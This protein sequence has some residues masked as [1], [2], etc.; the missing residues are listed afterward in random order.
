MEILKA[1]LRDIA[2]EASEFRMGEPWRPTTESLV[3]I[4]PI[5]RQAQKQRDYITLREAGTKV[6]IED[7]GTIKTLKV[8]NKAELAVFILAALTLAGDTQ[9]RIVDHGTVLMPSEEEQ[10]VSVVCAHETAGISSGAIMNE[11]EVAPRS[12]ETELY[13]R[14]GPRSL[15]NQDK[16]WGKIRAY[17]AGVL[18]SDR[19]DDLRASHSKRIEEVKAMLHKVRMPADQVGIAIL[20]PNGIGSFECFDSPDSWKVMGMSLLEKEVEALS[21]TRD[22][23]DSVFQYQPERASHV[24]RTFLRREFTFSTV[25]SNRNWETV[26]VRA[27]GYVG[28]ATILNN[29]VIHVSVGRK[30]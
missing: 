26:T 15:A 17:G 30:K 13:E 20:L 1:L 8:K 21:Q 29:N 11:E 19:A 23:F 14:E 6:S 12:V 4:V 5:T 10:D 7:S 28:E 18:P 2:N 25:D 3:A 27:R 22:D 24:L 16:V 9:A